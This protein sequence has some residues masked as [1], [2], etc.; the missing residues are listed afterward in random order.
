MADV[1]DTFYALSDAIHGYGAQLLKGDGASPET[2]QA[3]AGVESITPGEMTTADMR[4]THLRSPDA[5][6]EHAPGMRDSGPF[7]LGL[8]W[9]PED[10]TQS[11]TG[12]GSGSFTGG[13]LIADWRARTVHNWKILV[14]N[15]SPDLEW[16]F[17]GYVSRFQP[18]TI[19][20]E[21]M[22]RATAAIQPTE[23]YDADLP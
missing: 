6:H 18:G 13:G 9:L 5:H 1:T 15:G 2:F 4:R 12:G 7:E 11:N 20:T 17:T 23:A 8:Y 21:D 3:V 19:G 14:N 10:E 16:P 22:I